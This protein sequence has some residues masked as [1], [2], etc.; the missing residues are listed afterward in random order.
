MTEIKKDWFSVCSITAWLL[1]LP[2]ILIANSYQFY[3]Q[4]ELI[5]IFIAV[6]GFILLY[7]R[8]YLK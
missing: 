5:G 1:F 7:I 4:N 2:I 3:M 6:I 8:E